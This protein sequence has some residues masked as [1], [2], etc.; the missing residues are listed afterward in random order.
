MTMAS[1][2]PSSRRRPARRVGASGPLTGTGASP[3]IHGA[4]TWPR[5]Y[6]VPTLVGGTAISGAALADATP[7]GAPDDHM[8]GAAQPDSSAAADTAASARKPRARTRSEGRS[9]K[10]ISTTGKGF[11]CA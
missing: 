4:S 8:P 6:Q 10:F 7:T 3:A 5:S 9:G 11:T 2:R 1:Q